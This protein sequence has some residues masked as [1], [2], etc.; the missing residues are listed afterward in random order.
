MNRFKKLLSAVLLGTSIITI[1]PLEA[2]ASWKKDNT[3]WWYTEGDS[4]VR[5]AWRYIGGKWYYFDNSGYIKTGWM[6]N[7]GKWYYLNNNGAM[8]TGWIQ[9]KFKWY[10]L[11]DNGVMKVGW[12]KVDGDWYYAEN[13]GSMKTGWFNDNG[14]WRYLAPYDKGKMEKDIWMHDGYHLN[15]EGIADD[16]TKYHLLDIFTN[17]MVKCE[18]GKELVL[19]GSPGAVSLMNN[20]PTRFCMGINDSDIY[21]EYFVGLNTLNIYDQNGQIVDKAVLVNK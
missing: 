8:Q 4:Y 6:Q 10:Y 5:N 2:N 19:A 7:N 3:G 17:N 11:D 20:E 14:N 12:I 16:S 21:E 9:D 18:S 1:T 13:S 15:S